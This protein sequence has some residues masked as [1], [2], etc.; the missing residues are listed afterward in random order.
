MNTSYDFRI[1]VDL[2][3]TKIEVAALA[4]D[5]TLQLRRRIPTPQGYDATVAGIADLVRAASSRRWVAP[6]AWASAFPG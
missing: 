5:G 6:A 1:G 3:G 4:P 2:G